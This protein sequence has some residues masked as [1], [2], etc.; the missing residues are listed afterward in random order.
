[1]SREWRKKGFKANFPKFLIWA[2]CDDGAI[3]WDNKLSS[4]QTNK[5]EADLGEKFICSAVPC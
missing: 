1:M 4:E 5:T 3:P 2:L